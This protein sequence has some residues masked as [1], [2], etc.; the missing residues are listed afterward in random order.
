MSIYIS[1]FII[2]NNENDY[3]VLFVHVSI[4]IS[5]KKIQRKKATHTCF[6]TTNKIN[7]QNTQR[8]PIITIKFSIWGESLINIVWSYNCEQTTI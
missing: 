1:L 4:Q 3:I 7:I 5:R 2:K 6:T 8:L